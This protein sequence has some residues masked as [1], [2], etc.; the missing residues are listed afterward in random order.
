MREACKYAICM[1]KMIQIRNVP[2]RVHAKLKARAAM[3]HMSLSDYLLHEL[4][5]HLEYP[6]WA[7]VRE[8]LPRYGDHLKPSSADIIRAERDSR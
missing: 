2:D 6:T 4:Q 1:S 8:R 5:K 3:A 7:E